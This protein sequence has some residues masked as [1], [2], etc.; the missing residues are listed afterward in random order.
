VFA[1]QIR[2]LIAL[3]KFNVKGRD[4]V[5]SV[6]LHPYFDLVFAAFNMANQRATAQQQLPT[7]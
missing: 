6:D 3:E 7:N 5:A 4:L 1:Q 2:Q